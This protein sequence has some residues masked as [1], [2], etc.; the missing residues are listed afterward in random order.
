MSDVVGPAAYRLGPGVAQ[1]DD[2]TNGDTYLAQLPAGPIHVLTGSG[3]VI[4]EAV[5]SVAEDHVVDE[6][7]QACGLSGTE[8]ADDVRAFVAHLRESGLIEPLE[9]SAVEPL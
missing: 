3:T 5:L 2:D 7:A 4:L 1:A 9:P 6:V 8:I